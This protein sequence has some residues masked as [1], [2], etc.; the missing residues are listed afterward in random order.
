MGFILAEGR[1]HADPAA[2]V[3]YPGND[4]QVVGETYSQDEFFRVAHEFVDE[5]ADRPFF[6][7]LPLVTTHLAIQVPGR[8]P[9]PRR[10][11]PHDPRGAVRP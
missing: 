9:R 8:R 7:Y 5:N 4:R 10:V 1:P 6:L 2:R 11:P 3:N